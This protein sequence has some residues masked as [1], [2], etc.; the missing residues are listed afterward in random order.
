MRRSSSFLSECV[1]Q[2]DNGL[3]ES[4]G[5]NSHRAKQVFYYADSLDRSLCDVFEKVRQCE[6]L[7]D[8]FEALVSQHAIDE[9]ST[10]RVV[11][12]LDIFLPMSA[13]DAERL[14]PHPGGTVDKCSCI[15]C[16][17]DATEA[18]SRDDQLLHGAIQHGEN[19]LVLEDRRMLNEL[20]GQI[21]MLN[22]HMYHLWGMINFIKE[23]AQQAYVILP[24]L[25]YMPKSMLT[26]D[27]SCSAVPSSILRRSSFFVDANETYG[28]PGFQRRRSSQLEEGDAPKI[29]GDA[30]VFNRSSKL[31]SHPNRLT[32]QSQDSQLAVQT[33]PAGK[34]VASG[35]FGNA[36]CEK[37]IGGNAVVRPSTPALESVKYS[38]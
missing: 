38:I 28:N 22:D 7:L 33:T 18:A 11:E 16:F 15:G 37:L 26:F 9:L 25:V 17:D 23:L 29:C 19:N 14:L 10:D 13:P 30:F 8:A 32:D 36:N 35:V 1:S 3:A 31:Y 12:S 5:L 24:S 6:A 20:S 27:Q 21:K 4:M 34:H 2:D